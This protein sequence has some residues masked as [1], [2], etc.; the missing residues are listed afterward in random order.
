MNVE[1]RAYPVVDN[2]LVDGWVKELEA[3]GWRVT[4]DE[5][6]YFST[7]KA[8][9]TVCI[10]CGTPIEELAEYCW[11]CFHSEYR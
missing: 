6:E 8:K 10:G 1:E 11:D 4:V 3:E 9:R 2:D 5:Y 7:I